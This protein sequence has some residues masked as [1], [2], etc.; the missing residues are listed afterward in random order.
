MSQLRS[1]QVAIVVSAVDQP[2]R[3]PVSSI[4]YDTTA[5]QVKNS[6]VNRAPITAT[7]CIIAN[8]TNTSVNPTLPSPGSFSQGATA[9][10][11]IRY[12]IAAKNSQVT[13][14]N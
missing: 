6:A 7:Q 8:S 5:Q 11:K 9:S 10:T 12:I 1:Q 14:L 13:S 2:V 4:A 3:T